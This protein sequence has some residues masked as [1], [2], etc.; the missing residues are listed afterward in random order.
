MENKK[1]KVLIEV[2]EG[3][4]DIESPIGWG[5]VKIRDEVTRQIKEAVIEQFISK[6]KL[7]KIKPIDT[8][9]IRDLIKER[10]VDKILNTN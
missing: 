3:W 8:K 9:E 1:Y 5:S 6:V 2:P 10:M 4:F 7:P